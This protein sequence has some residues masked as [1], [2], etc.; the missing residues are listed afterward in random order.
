LIEISEILVANIVG[1]VLMLVVIRHFGRNSRSRLLSDRL[2]M[3]MAFLTGSLCML[4]TAAFL[5]DGHLFPG[6]IAINYALNM[7]LFACA[8]LFAFTWTMY[9][10][11]KLFGGLRKK[12]TLLTALP[13]FLCLLVILS[14]PFTDWLFTISPEN[15]YRRSLFV[16][17]VYL[18]TYAYLIYGGINVQRHRRQVDRYMFIPVSTFVVPILIGSTIQFFCYG[19]ATQWISVAVGVISLYVNIQSESMYVDSLSGLYNRLYLD[20]FLRCECEKGKERAALL[21]IMIDIDHFKRIN[22]ELGHLMGDRAIMRTGQ[23]LRSSIKGYDAFAARY[24]GDEFMILA[25]L[26]STEEAQALA[27]AVLENARQ[28]NAAQQEPFPLS[29]SIGMTAFDMEKDTLDSFLSRMD[30]R[31]YEMKYER[32]RA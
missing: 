5:I 31:M 30:R 8:V 10:D 13:S 24:G 9:T 29:F 12:R 16:Y 3:L 22:D 15:V 23:V 21:G 25:H 11:S 19:L 4:E 20:S 26:N 6:A 17:V 28:F 2:F 27:E 1:A 32:P 7:M 14:T 18:C